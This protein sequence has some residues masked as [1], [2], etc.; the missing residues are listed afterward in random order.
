MPNFAFSLLN[1]C[2]RLFFHHSL[3]SARL[4]KILFL[5]QLFSLMKRVCCEN[6]ISK[7]LSRKL[8]DLI[9]LAGQL[10]A[11]SSASFE[12]ATTSTEP[13]MPIL[14]RS[15][16]LAQQQRRLTPQDSGQVNQI[17]QGNPINHPKSIRFTGC[18]KLCQ[19][20]FQNEIFLG[21][22]ALYCRPKKSNF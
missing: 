20:N 7:N 21:T 3:E 10:R 14:L 1:F 11:S 8:S 15:S 17:L 12:M 19:S 22:L 18:L 4:T 5:S 2:L 16:R 9:G 13:K 6:S